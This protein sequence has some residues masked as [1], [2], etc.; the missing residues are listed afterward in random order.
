MVTLPRHLRRTRE[1]IPFCRRH[2]SGTRIFVSD[3]WRLNFAVRFLTIFTL[4]NDVAIANKSSERSAPPASAHA[5]A[6][7]A[8]CAIRTRDIAESATSMV[9]APTAYQCEK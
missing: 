8:R 7:C 4:F 3:W 9:R 6:L 1:S 2:D 5:F